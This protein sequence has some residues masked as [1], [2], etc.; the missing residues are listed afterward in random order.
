MKIEMTND[1]IK[2]L[3]YI[4]AGTFG[5]VYLKDNLAIKIYREYIR[6]DFREMQP[7]PCLRIRKGKF[8]RL[9]KRNDKLL[10]SDTQLDE[11]Y[12]DGEFRGVV[13]KYY[14]GEIFETLKLKPI[15]FKKEKSLELIRNVRELNRHLIYC[16]DCKEDNIIVTDLGEVKL[17]DLD[18][19]LTLVPFLPNPLWKKLCFSKTKKAITNIFYDNLLDFDDTISSHVSNYA[20]QETLR[21]S[22]NY[23]M[24]K[25][26]INSIR[27]VHDILFI[28]LIDIL[29]VD[30]IFLKNF[31]DN[32]SINLVIAI[33]NSDVLFKR[34]FILDIFDYLETHDISIYDIFSFT[35]NY[36]EKINEYIISHDSRNNLLFQDNKILEKK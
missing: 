5:T 30:L 11:L 33:N 16:L 10:Y 12:I 1:E 25:K 32:N 23:S 4:A 20:N 2:N 13:K 14:E 27:S 22:K 8:A 21:K 35:N 19:C 18:D 3:K 6:D 17:I 29:D 28:K 31:L 36:E 9:N 34:Q 15:D 7:N 24:L 26:N